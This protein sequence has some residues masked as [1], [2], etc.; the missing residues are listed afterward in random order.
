ME[1]NGTVINAFLFELNEIGKIK[2][3]QI[4]VKSIFAHW[5]VI[6]THG[7]LVNGK[8]QVKDMFANKKGFYIHDDIGK[9]RALSLD[10]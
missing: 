10:I 7:V 3:N 8:C 1:V 5:F 6:N 2:S 9:Q 4:A